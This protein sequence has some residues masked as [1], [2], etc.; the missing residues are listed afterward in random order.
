MS[1]GIG[2]GANVVAANLLNRESMVVVDVK[3]ELAATA[4]RHRRERLGHRV[5]LLNPFH[6]T[7]D[8][9]L[10]IAL[11]D[12]GYDP[13]LL[14]RDSSAVKDDAELLASM[15]LPMPANPDLVKSSFRA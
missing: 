7:L 9:E 1:N 6:A 2:K 12:D 10:G 13:L 5:V 4:P 14:L 11:A 8:V 15:L 3:G